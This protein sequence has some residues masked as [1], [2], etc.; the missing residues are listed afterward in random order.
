MEEG[1]ELVILFDEMSALAEGA[2]AGDFWFTDAGNQERRGCL[3]LGGVAGGSEEDG[4]AL[5]DVDGAE[6]L[7][8]ETLR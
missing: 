8:A 1:V 2:G 4:I 6:E 7:V 3:G 5:L